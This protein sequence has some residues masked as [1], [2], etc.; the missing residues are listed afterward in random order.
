MSVSIL[1]QGGKWIGEE[2]QCHCF[3]ECGCD[4]CVQFGRNLLSAGKDPQDDKNSKNYTCPNCPWCKGA[5]AWKNKFPEDELNLSNQ[6]FREF[7]K[8]IN[9]FDLDPDELAGEIKDRMLDATIKQATFSL[10]I[11]KRIERET[12]D[13]EIYKGEGGCT[14]YKCG[15]DPDYWQEVLVAYLEI[16]TKAKQQDTYLYYG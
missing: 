7:A 6:H 5:G 8:I 12:Y 16:A 14:V 2:H 13:T 11:R 9:L 4:S 1:I 15:I 3:Y 10:N